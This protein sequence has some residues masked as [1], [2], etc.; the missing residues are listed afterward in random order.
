MGEARTK[1]LETFDGL[2]AP[3]RLGPVEAIRGGGRKRRNTLLQSRR[4]ADKRG[5][6]ELNGAWVEELSSLGSRVGAHGS[7][8]EPHVSRG[9]LA[10]NVDQKWKSNPVHAAR[11]LAELDLRKIEWERARW[12]E[13]VKGTVQS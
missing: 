12:H 6:K 1:R 5:S 10:V 4:E 8:G 2:C 11:R 9:G 13:G 3:G 7:R